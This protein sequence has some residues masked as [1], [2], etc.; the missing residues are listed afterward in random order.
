M[1]ALLLFIVGSNKQ[2]VS[3]CVM[4]VGFFFIVDNLHPNLYCSMLKDLGD[5]L[6]DGEMWSMM[7]GFIMVQAPSGF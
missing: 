6:P 2:L 3:Q 7:R 4:F 5:L 1:S